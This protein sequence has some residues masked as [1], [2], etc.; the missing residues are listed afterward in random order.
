MPQTTRI[1]E[2]ADDLTRRALAHPER[3]KPEVSLREPA[4]RRGVAAIEE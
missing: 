2:A 1:A 4:S 3:G